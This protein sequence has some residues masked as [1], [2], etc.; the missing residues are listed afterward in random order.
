MTAP[1][2]TKGTKVPE[3]GEIV[4]RLAK[5]HLVASLSGDRIFGDAIDFIESQNRL[6]ESMFDAH[7]RRVM[8][9]DRA[10][11][12]CLRCGAGHEWIE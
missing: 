9:K 4:E 8:S 6:I 11:H 12:K 2:A 1:D 7:D 3:P 10:V 5:R